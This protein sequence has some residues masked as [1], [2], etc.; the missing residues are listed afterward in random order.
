M[1]KNEVTIGGTYVVKVSGRLAP[2]RIVGESPYGGYDGVNT[3]T[4]R[5][6]RIRTAARLRRRVDRA[7]ITIGTRTT[8]SSSGRAG[9]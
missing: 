8:R 2:V 6:V 5:S 9:R 3:A 7:P 4:G 1:K